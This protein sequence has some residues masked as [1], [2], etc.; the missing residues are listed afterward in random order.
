M[1]RYLTLFN[2]E[3]DA[4]FDPEKLF[5]V[6]KTS[7]GWFRYKFSRKKSV[8]KKANTTQLVANGLSAALKH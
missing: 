3:L 8:V 7:R 6:K 2:A 1:D 4:A 5:P